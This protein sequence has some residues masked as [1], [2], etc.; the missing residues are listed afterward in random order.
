MNKNKEINA[1]HVN[2]IPIKLK[3]LVSCLNATILFGLNFILTFKHEN[4]SQV[5]LGQNFCCPQK[6]CVKLV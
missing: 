6:I 2:H 1:D 5:S 4:C 3:W